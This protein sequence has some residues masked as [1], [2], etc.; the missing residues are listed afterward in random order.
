MA[1]KLTKKQAAQLLSAYENE[2]TAA[3]NASVA[4]YNKAVDADTEKTEAE[5]AAQQKDAQKTADTAY[6]R[7]ALDALI[8][9]RRIAETL[10]NLG[11]SDSGVAKSAAESINRKQA[12]AVRTATAAK[13]KVLSELSQKLI[14]AR[15]QAAAKKAKNAASVNKTLKGKIAEKKLTLNKSAV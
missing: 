7:A 3:A 13:R 15:E 1:T 8:E 5:I 4:A 12:V 10:S 14:T 9:R 11:L 2:Q 6:D